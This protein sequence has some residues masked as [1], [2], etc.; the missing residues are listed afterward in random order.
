MAAA[1]ADSLFPGE[2]ND[3][4][5]AADDVP[6]LLAD[7][8]V[9]GAARHHGHGGHKEEEEGHRRC[10]IARPLLFQE[11]RHSAANAGWDIA[12]L[13][14]SLSLAVIVLRNGIRRDCCCPYHLVITTDLSVV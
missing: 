9:V 11:G 6:I 1:V 5:V 13:I 10:W 12:C 2:L 3:E 8:V 4:Q 14:I 7:G